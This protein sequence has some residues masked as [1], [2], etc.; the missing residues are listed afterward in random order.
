MTAS[1]PDRPDR[2]E[3][4]GTRRARHRNARRDRLVLPR[5]RADQRRPSQY[6]FSA[7]H[8]RL[9][10]AA[11]A[12]APGRLWGGRRGRLRVVTLEVG[13]QYLIPCGATTFIASG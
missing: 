9:T 10:T 4:R 5:L 2:P 12:P 1:R 3:C 8:N 11:T 6:S 7:T 13:Y